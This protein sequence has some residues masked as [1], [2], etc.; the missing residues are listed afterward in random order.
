MKS[1]QQRIEAGL[2]VRLIGGREL[3][4]TEAALR[5]HH[6]ERRLELARGKIRS[7]EDL[8]ERRQQRLVK[9]HDALQRLPI[10][11]AQLELSVELL[12]EKVAFYEEWKRNSDLDADA[13][14]VLAGLL[15]D[16]QGTLEQ[17]H[18]VVDA[19]ITRVEGML[20]ASLSEPV[21]P[22]SESLADGAQLVTEIRR[23]LDGEPLAGA[24][25][26]MPQK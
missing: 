14:A 16:A 15:G 17:A 9:L 7:F 5:V 8:C 18:Q 2:P 13:D 22:I 3:L 10:E 19:K 20:A 21:A 11:L 12:A 1:I 25:T 26:P 4:T 6:T 23:I 24:L